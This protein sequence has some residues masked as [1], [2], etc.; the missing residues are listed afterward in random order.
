MGKDVEEIPMWIGEFRLDRAAQ[1][2]WRNGEPVDLVPQVWALLVCLVERAGR[3]VSKDEILEAAWP[4][5][6]V[7][8]MALSQA[9]RQAPH[10]LRRRR[11]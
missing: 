9:V 1:R 5:V 10:R 4:G 8:D 3:I 2:L 11:P 6:A 7:S